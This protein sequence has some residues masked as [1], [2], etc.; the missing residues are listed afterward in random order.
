MRQIHDRNNGL[1]DRG[2]TWSTAPEP[3]ALLPANQASRE[4]DRDIVGCGINDDDALCA[5]FMAAATS[6][7]GSSDNT[8]HQP[9]YTDDGYSTFD[10]LISAP[11]TSASAHFDTSPA[12]DLAAASTA[13]SATTS[14]LAFTNATQAPTGNN[15]N[16][17][18]C[19]YTMSNGKGKNVADAAQLDSLATTDYYTLVPQLQMDS[20]ERRHS[21]GSSTMLRSATSNSL[22]DLVTPGSTFLNPADV[23]S[24][25]LL[26]NTTNAS[27]SASDIA[28]A[29]AFASTSAAYS[30][31]SVPATPA[32]ALSFFAG[33]SAT[34]PLKPLS[35]R[36]PLPALQQQLEQGSRGTPYVD[37]LLSAY[38]SYLNTPANPGAACLG[39]PNV[40]VPAASSSS[41]LFAPLDEIRSKDALRDDLLHQIAHAGP[42]FRQNLVHALVDMIKPS[43]AY[44]M[45][46]HGVPRAT[47]REPASAA[48]LL[49]QAQ[50]LASA[51]TVLDEVSDHFASAAAP[52]VTA[53]PLIANEAPLLESL[54]GLLSPPAFADNVPA[55]PDMFSPAMPTAVAPEDMFRSPQLHTISEEEDVPLAQYI[56]SSDN[57]HDP[58]EKEAVAPTTATKRK[59][60]VDDDSG[61]E[62][63]AKFH[64]DICN[65]GFS[66]QYNMRTHRLT[67]NP[68][69]VIARPYNCEACSRTFTR[70]HDL[71]RHQVLHDASDAFKCSV[72]SRAFARLDVLDR[73]IR[74][75]HKD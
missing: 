45:V 57:Q 51:A 32:H 20:T 46:D 18:D 5:L 59:R 72:C 2:P 26:T 31:S 62:K 10:T 69:S 16:T 13:Y 58:K 22:S 30:S 41:T 19:Y 9:A 50:N 25:P 54:L 3:G 61:S 40:R 27:I 23:F 35:Y 70:K 1:V 29:A 68:N 44:Q 55:T 66:R 8:L 28:V 14:T 11:A 60:S 52:D 7:S 34:A 43:V 53:T 64:C 48:S 38:G 21:S 39:S 6:S 47:S 12:F 17:L 75:L 4:S 15:T 74:A 42:A 67:H 24:T 49:V 73:H 63:H 71:V 56:L 36:D 33:G 65:R 37:P